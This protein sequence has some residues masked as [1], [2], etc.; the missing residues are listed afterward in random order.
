MRWLWVFLVVGMLGV[1]TAGAQQPATPPVSLDVD[2]AVLE[3]LLPDFLDP[4]RAIT[5][6]LLQMGPQFSP[7]STTPQMRNILASSWDLLGLRLTHVAEDPRAALDPEGLRAETR[8]LIGRGSRGERVLV[9]GQARVDALDTAVSRWQS[10]QYTSDEATGLA[11][12]AS[13]MAD[14]EYAALYRSSALYANL[15][16]GRTREAV[17]RGRLPSCP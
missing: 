11:L 6:A 14:P 5:Q 9:A 7:V 13:V 8:Y 12:V 4:C 10:G 17:A 15:G 3:R 2:S 16:V 1:G